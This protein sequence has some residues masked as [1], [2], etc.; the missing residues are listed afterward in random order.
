MPSPM[1]PAGHPA[2]SYVCF[3]KKASTRL[4]MLRA[5]V[6]RKSAFPTSPT[7]RLPAPS[8]PTPIPAC[9]TTTSTFSSSCDEPNNR[10]R[11]PLRLGSPGSSP[12]RLHLV[13]G[14]QHHPDLLREDSDSMVTTDIT[15]SRGK[16]VQRQVDDARETA[17]QLAAGRRAGTG[18]EARGVVPGANADQGIARRRACPRGRAREGDSAPGERGA[19]MA[20]PHVGRVPFSTVHCRVRPRAGSAAPC[21]GRC[22]MLPMPSLARR[23][24]GN[25]SLGLEATIDCSAPRRPMRR[26]KRPPTRP[27]ATTAVVHLAGFI[28]HDTRTFNGGDFATRRPPRAGAG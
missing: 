14:H 16:R 20:G 5:G 24:N 28:A 3:S 23:G 4:P 11:R 10:T 19:G 9:C 7:P 26:H 25:T 12:G 21:D 6:L 8:R 27:F 13:V 18:E 17:P 1:S 22:R 2:D 15:A